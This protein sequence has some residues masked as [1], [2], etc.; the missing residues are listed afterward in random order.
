MGIRLNIPARRDTGRELGPPLGRICVAV[1]SSDTIERVDF[2]YT[3]NHAASYDMRVKRP[4]SSERGLR[5]DIGYIG[6][7]SRDECPAGRQLDGVHRA[8]GCCTSGRGGR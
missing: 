5:N 7:D 1:C 6:G 2:S 3:K 8:C 4:V